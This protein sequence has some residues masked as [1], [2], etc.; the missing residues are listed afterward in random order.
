MLVTGIDVSKALLDV[1]MAEGPVY[2]FANSGPGIRRLLQHRARAG[3]TQAVCETT[4][5][6]ELLVNPSGSP[7]SRC[8]W[9][10]PCGCVPSRAPV[11][12]RPRPTPWMSGCWRAMARCSRPRTPVRQRTRRNAR[13]C[14]NGC[15]GAGNGLTSGSRHGTGWTR[16]SVLPSVSPPDDT[17]PGST[18]RTRPCGS[19]VL[20]SAHKPRG[21][22][23]YRGWRLD[24]GHA[25]GL[26]ARMGPTGQQGLDFA[27]G[28]R[29][30]VAGQ[31][32][33][34]RPAVD[35]GRSGRRAPRA[36]HGGTVRDSAGRRPP[37]F[38]SG[39]AA[40]RQNGQGRPGGGHAQAAPAPECGGPPRDTLVATG[41]V[42]I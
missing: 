21:T 24:R 5:G 15:A 33:Q 22:A 35:P 16:A 34:T 10:I 29:T 28:A 38:P 37:I 23:A 36:V 17:W 2:R 32:P 42:A 13:R 26:S 27:G 14:S 39:L 12:T 1:A 19:A 11:A 40:T 18:R 4:G 31:W 7:A 8:R 30:V 9:P 41:G 20:P 25:G 3:A 6:Y